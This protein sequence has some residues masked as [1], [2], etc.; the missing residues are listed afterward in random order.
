[1]H[2]I[3]FDQATHEIAKD[4]PE[5]LTLPAYC[6]EAVTVSCWQLNWRE[7]FKVFFCGRFWFTQMNFRHP[8]QPQRPSV[9]SPFTSA[10]EK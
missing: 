5:Y 8:L 4:Q 1:M 10:L 6:D 3:T 2:P 7:R 9:D